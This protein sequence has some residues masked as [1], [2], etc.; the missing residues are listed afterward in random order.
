MKKISYFFIV[1]SS[2][3]MMTMI[4]CVNNLEGNEDNYPSN[5][6]TVQEQV[7]AMKSSVLELESIQTKLS[8]VSGFEEYVALIEDC[9]TSVKEHIASVENGLSG[10]DA[11]IA[12]MELQG[13]VAYAAGT[14]KVALDIAGNDDFQKDMTSLEKSVSAWLGKS[15][16]TYSDVLMGAYASQAAV[17]GAASQLSEHHGYVDAILS[18]VEAGLRSGVEA[19]ELA[20]VLET[21][22]NNLTSATELDSKVDEIVLNL[23]TECAM[24]VEALFDE[25][26]SYDAS[27]LKKASTQARIQLKSVDVTIS[28][29]VSRIETIETDIEEIKTR[30][31]QLEA[32]VNELLGMIQSLTFVSEYSDN[33][34]I[35]YYRMTDVINQERAAEEKRE[36]VPAET[37]DLTFLVRPAAVADALAQ[38]WN[39]SLSVIGYY[40]NRI[41]M[42]AIENIQSFDIVN[43]VSTSGKGLLTV[44]VNNAFDDDFYFKEKGAMLALTVESGKNNCAS[45]FIEIEPRDI[46]G[47]VY[48]ESLKLTPEELSIQNYDMYKLV[49][50][51]IPADVTDQGLV[52]ND[53]GSEFF[54]VDENGLLTA[55]AVGTSDVM[56]TA[57]ATDE[58]GRPLSAICKV[59]VT[60]A[61]RIFGPSFIEIDDSATL[62]LESPTYINPANVTWELEWPGNNIY[63]DLIDNKDGTSTIRGIMINFGKPSGASSLAQDEYL[64]MGVKC[65]I[66][67]NSDTL[68]LVHNVKV[69]EVQPQN[70]VIEGLANDKNK[71]TVK[72]DSVF[73]FN[74]S[75]EPV[76]VNNDLFGLRYQTNN[77]SVVSFNNITGKFTA[78]DYGTASLDVIVDD[79]TGDSYFHPKRD[80]GSYFKRTVDVTV[81]PYWVET[82]TLPNIEEPIS[83][84]ATGV[85]VP[86]FTSDV[87]GHLPSVQTLIW[88]SDDPTVIE[89]NAETGA[90]TAVGEGNA[91]ITARTTGDHSTEDGEPIEATCEITVAILENLPNVGDYYY[92]DGSW[93]SSYVP[94]NNPI[95]VVFAI[96]DATRTDA[97]LADKFD[98]LTALVVGLNEYNSAFGA[99]STGG[100]STGQWFIDKGYDNANLTAT[101]GYSNSIGLSAYRDERQ[102][103]ASGVEDT[104]F[105]LNLTNAPANGTSKWYIPSYYEMYLLYQ[106]KDIVNNSLRTRGIEISDNNYWTS[107]LQW[108]NKWHDIDNLY[109]FDMSAGEWGS[110][111]DKATSLPVRVVLAF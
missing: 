89:V 93:S 87:E 61:I 21:L 5:V 18:D 97:M 2:L 83:V 64:D 91:T 85:F 29:L 26:S 58:F 95:G 79:K 62:E 78:K 101:N 103:G 68:R 63:L 4:S 99:I 14:V 16:E 94:A 57:N 81:E 15:F 100:V 48:A 13:Q 39:E 34:A 24:A 88:E 55:K 19:K 8:E 17:E 41:Q 86:I 3:L 110:A 54:S 92:I 20:S 33:K 47:K 106:A 31:S 1:M 102:G 59:N 74:A 66:T 84:G 25:P 60:P 70:I 6:A 10:A 23:E 108:P 104:A 35:A 40:A 42:R 22:A 65:I 50:E 76:N 46:S 9:A 90:Y 111:T 77:S 109:P 38:T 37:F 72:I 49:A 105:N 67:G 56:V 36:R 7:S 80:V 73:N 107:S 28:D 12:A 69:I 53:Y 32:D 44:T 82:L 11:A 98:N 71:T 52:W 96:V 43:A 27:T 51:V 45:E 75:I 30:I